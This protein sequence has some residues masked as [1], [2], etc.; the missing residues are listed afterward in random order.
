MS[1]HLKADNT[2]TLCG[3]ALSVLDH[4]VAGVVE[5]PDEATCEW[6]I[7][8]SRY[9]GNDSI[10]PSAQTSKITPTKDLDK[11]L[12]KLV[13]PVT[14]T[15]WQRV[16]EARTALQAWATQQVVEELKAIIAKGDYL[17]SITKNQATTYEYYVKE[18][19]N[20]LATLQRQQENTNA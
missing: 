18:M 4:K 5:L 2:Y 19:R 7:A 1:Q 14:T 15:E 16:G 11:I 12:G 3:I 20:R 9:G 6:C 17:N 10:I 8:K 13:M